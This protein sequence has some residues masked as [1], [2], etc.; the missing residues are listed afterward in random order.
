MTLG[1]G[2]QHRAQL[3][4]VASREKRTVNDLGLQLIAAVSEAANVVEPKIKEATPT[5]LHGDLL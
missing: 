3:G 1:I 4:N 2:T 5:E